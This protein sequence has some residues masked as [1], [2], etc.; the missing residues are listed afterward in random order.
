MRPVLGVVALG[1]AGAAPSVR[2]LLF[3]SRTI[4]AAA[5][6]L[7]AAHKHWNRGVCCA[8]SIGAVRHRSL[9][10]APM[11]RT[12]APKRSVP[13]RIPLV[14]AQAPAR[15]RGQLAACKKLAKQLVFALA[16][17]K[18]AHRQP[19]LPQHILASIPRRS[20]AALRSTSSEG[21]PSH[22]LLA[23]QHWQPQ[24]PARHSPAHATQ[25]RPSHPER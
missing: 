16:G 10:A 14:W 25:L 15:A 12:A 24:P 22:T 5:V 20:A 17:H 21:Q 8:H 18:G 4:E 13:R 1:S 9:L 23:S 19:T 3:V 7:C 6:H 2:Y 11:R